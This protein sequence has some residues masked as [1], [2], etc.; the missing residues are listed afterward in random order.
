LYLRE[1][2]TTDDAAAL[3][4]ARLETGAGSRFAA[5]A[6]GDGASEA[7]LAVVAQVDDEDLTAA[8][9]EL[10]DHAVTTRTLDEAHRWAHEAVAALAPLPNGPV[11]K[12]LTRFADTVVERTH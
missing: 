8:I 5:V 9:S 4:L 11:K 7:P 3:L 12:A 2:A 6:D 1:L 10:R